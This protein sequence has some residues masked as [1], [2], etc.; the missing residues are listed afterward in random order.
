[1]IHVERNLF[2]LKYLHGIETNVILRDSL[3]LSKCTALTILNK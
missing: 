2:E 3:N 1:M